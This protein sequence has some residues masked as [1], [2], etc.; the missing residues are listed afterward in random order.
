MTHFGVACS[1]PLQLQLVLIV[2]N[3]IQA[4]T[5][6]QAT[7]DPFA[8]NKLC[9]TVSLLDLDKRDEEVYLFSLKLK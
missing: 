9:D 8:P 5:I 7:W 4:F 2:F 6:S 1:E 3:F